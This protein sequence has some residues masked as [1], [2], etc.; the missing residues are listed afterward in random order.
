MVLTY[1]AGSLDIQWVAVATST[2]W[3]E[4][5]VA[6]SMHNLHYLHSGHFVHRPIHEIRGVWGKNVLITTAWFILFTWLLK[7]SSA[8]SLFGKHWQGT[9]A[10]S[11]RSIHIPL[12]QSS[13]LPAFQLCSFQLPVHLVKWL[14]T[15][16]ESLCNSMASHFSFQAKWR[17]RYAAQNTAL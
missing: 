9:H 10:H 16:H 5:H 6:G 8:M 2:L 1:V 13:L 14:A 12:P 11:E 7:V 15:A 4:V 17:T 3:M